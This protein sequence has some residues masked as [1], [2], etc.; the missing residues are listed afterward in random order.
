[1]Y[2]LKLIPIHQEK[3][4]PIAAQVGFIAVGAP[5][6]A[7]R[8][9]AEDQ[10]ILSLAV[11]G[12]AHY[13][14]ELQE[15]WLEKLADTF[16]KTGGS[17]TSALRS[18]IETLN[19]T[20]MERN[21]KAAQTGA[22]VSGA[23]NLAAVHRR[24]VY[25]AQTGLIHTY[26]LTQTGLAHFYDSSLMDRGLG[27]S[28]TPA[29][30]YYQAELGAGAYLF[31]TADAPAPT[32]TEARLCKDGFPSLEQLRRRLLD[33]SSPNLRLD[34]AQV[35]PGEGE[36][37]ILHQ[38]VSTPE[39]HKQPAPLIADQ[40]IVD[41][42]EMSTADESLV[43]SAVIDETHPLLTHEGVP[44]V[45]LPEEGLPLSAPPSGQISEDD[46]PS[47]SVEATE[48]AVT[49]PIVADHPSA[50]IEAEAQARLES[51]QPAVT[52]KSYPERKALQEQVG[53]IRDEGLKGLA[54]FFKWWG[55]AREKLA[56]FFN[57]L[58]ARSGLADE[59][60]QPGLPMRTQL[61]IVIV[62]P[63]VVV[64]IAMSIFL[65]RGRTLQYQSYLDQAEILAAS[66][67]VAED[68]LQARE[69]YA[70]ALQFLEQAESLRSTDEVTQLRANT[71]RILDILD[72]AQRLSYHPAIIGS[73]HEEINITRIISFGWD[74][75]MLDAQGG[76]VIHA[77]RGSKGYEIDTDFVC[78]AGGFSGGMVDML[79][80]MAPL[81]INNPYQ[82]HVL[83][84]DALGNVVFCGPGQDPV[85]QTLPRGEGAL[86]AVT[87]IASD[88][89]T[90]YVLDPSVEA[91]R[92]Y[93]STNGQFLDEPKLLF[94]GAGVSEKP[95]LSQVVD[96]A[97]NGAEI[98]LL[99]EDGK[100]A[101][102]VTT[103][104]PDKP[105]SC[106]NP[107]EFVDSRL[108]KENQPV[109]MPDSRFVSVL[110]SAPPD[111]AVNILDADHADIFRFSLRFRLDQRM[112]SDFGGY[113]V[114]SPVATAF[115][116]GVDRIAFVAFG[117]QVFWAYIE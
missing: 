20:L 80:D 4:Q 81:P 87:R 76:Q 91:V 54:G 103:G 56:N 61:S 43:E 107:V 6:R 48:T 117:H 58:L 88:G 99:R 15:V 83:A 10:L 2:D 36:I 53:A 9:R 106:E 51:V 21:L 92:V 113:E 97:V 93:W 110:Y 49:P 108:G 1:M 29:I 7:A 111:P 109:V 14:A 39:S 67:E 24:A 90:L 52:E 84:A 116:I 32:W 100:L 33:Q 55:S 82:A 57:K 8:S 63:L 44:P 18:L 41:I 64:A 5:R 105:V 69:D 115:T 75:Y 95:A 102:C 38:P 27:Y 26:A 50:E 17:V 30:R 12:D 31:T 25:I 94:G 98:Y 85:V 11:S 13:A 46:E 114:K 65:V 101:H 19:L 23:I 34:L 59:T 79:V 66:A 77:T 89:N 62:V 73:L 37:S 72:G 96:L 22:A 45:E 78:R 16:F 104:L 60:G 86:G 35:V 112:R 68:P 3:G 40:E 47:I 74:L 71:Q 42:P 70:Q 28:R